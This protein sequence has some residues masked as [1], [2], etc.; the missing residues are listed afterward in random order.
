MKELAE[1][2]ELVEFDELVESVWKV[3]VSFEDKK[4]ERDAPDAA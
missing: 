4:R 3:C 1:L 2:N